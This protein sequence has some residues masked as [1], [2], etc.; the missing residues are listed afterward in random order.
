MPCSGAVPRCTESGEEEAALE[1]EQD[2][3]Q[4]ERSWGGAGRSGGGWLKC[5]A[6]PHGC[7]QWAQG[8]ASCAAPLQRRARGGGAVL[9]TPSSCQTHS[10]G[11]A[12]RTLVPS[13]G[14]VAC[15]EQLCHGARAGPSGTH[16]AEAAGAGRGKG[17][18]CVGRAISH[19]RVWSMGHQQPPC[20]TAPRRAAPLSLGQSPLHSAPKPPATET[21]EQNKTATPST[22]A[23]ASRPPSTPRGALATASRAHAARGQI[24]RGKTVQ[25]GASPTEPDPGLAQHALCQ[26]A[27]AP[28]GPPPEPDVGAGVS[29][30]SRGVVAANAIERGWWR[31]SPQRCVVFVLLPPPAVALLL[32]WGD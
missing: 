27:L 29:Q 21:S 2:G 22:R 17:W 25:V 15:H 31:G 9:S 20:R 30:G 19:L 13:K 14:A 24:P 16:A 28:A 11:Q 18:G 6:A 12:Q 1:A 23:P 5:V 8:A 4:G 10:R 7:I 32:R 3:V 26:T